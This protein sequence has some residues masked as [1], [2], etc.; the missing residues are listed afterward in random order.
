MK[1]LKE[2]IIINLIVFLVIILSNIFSF[3][4]CLFY[5]IF[6]IPCPGCGISRACGLVL[7]GKFIESFSF[8]ILH[9]VIFILYITFIVWN[10]ID[11]KR[12]TDTFNRFVTKYKAIL[13]IIAVIIMLIAWFVNLRNPLLY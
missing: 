8:S 5:N 2:F 9:I 10:F 11:Y 7:Q 1:F 3:R 6:H 13:I 4:I 12:N